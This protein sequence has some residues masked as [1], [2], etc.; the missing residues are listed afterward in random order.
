MVK[1][2]TKIKS[3]KESG[4]FNPHPERINAPLFQNSPFFDPKDLVQVKY[5]MLRRVLIDGASKTETA[6]LF[7]VSRPTFYDTE[8]AFITAG[9]A[10]LLPQQRGPKEAHKIDIQ[11]MTFIETCISENQQI[12]AKKLAEL[13]QAQFNISV[14]PRSIERAIIRKKKSNAGGS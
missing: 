5:E 1:R 9:M 11:I 12:K 10:G 6:A 14:H 7:G 3:L 2:D 4:S 8:S 13:I